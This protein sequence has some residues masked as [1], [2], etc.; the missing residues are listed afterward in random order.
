MASHAILLHYHQTGVAVAIEAQLNKAL[1][2][3]RAFALGPLC[4]ARA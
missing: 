2:L 3:T 4:T 1:E